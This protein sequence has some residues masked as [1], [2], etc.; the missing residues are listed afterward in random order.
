MLTQ[1]RQYRILKL[2]QD[3]KTAT[4]AE[5]T[6][7]TD[8]SEATIRRDLTAL[9]LS[10]KLVKVHGGATLPPD[11]FSTA[12]PD[13]ST[14]AALHAAEKEA[15]GRYAATLVHDEDFIYLDAGTTTER[16]IEHLAGS[17]ATF[18]TNGIGHL[19]RLTALGLRCYLLGGQFKPVTEAMIGTM[20]TRAL[21]QFNFSKCFMGVNGISLE[22]GYTPPDSEEAAVKTAAMAQSYLCY[23]LADHSKFGFVSSVTFAPARQACIITDRLHDES[24]RTMTT[25]KEVN[26]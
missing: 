4:V 26:V 19:R 21:G 9:A 25:I 2:L 1:E 11:A 10:G 22:H 3:Q 7:L 6:R 24:Y 5:L 15:I 13:V 8:S 14:K 12:E 18:V 17:R 16:V 23:I 20:A